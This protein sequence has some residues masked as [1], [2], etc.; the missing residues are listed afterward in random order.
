MHDYSSIT[1]EII[2]LLELLDNVENKSKIIASVHF[3]SFKHKIK[4]NS[5]GEFFDPKI[6]C[7]QNGYTSKGIRLFSI[8]NEY[9][10]DGFRGR[11]S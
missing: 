6:K 7:Y 5:V 3:L 1:L 11:D 2:N 10:I 8:G 4:A 9:E